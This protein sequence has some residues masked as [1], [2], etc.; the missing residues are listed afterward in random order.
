MQLAD[1]ET[2]GIEPEV[3]AELLEDVRAVAC[4]HRLG[5][6]IPDAVREQ[7]VTPED[8]DVGRLVGKCGWCGRTMDMSQFESLKVTSPPVPAS[9]PLNAACIG[10]RT[11]V[12][13]G[14]R[15]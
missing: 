14:D 15:E 10:R 2:S 9:L 11:R 3:A 12:L 8:L 6:E 4:R 13:Q 7:G 5:D 1:S